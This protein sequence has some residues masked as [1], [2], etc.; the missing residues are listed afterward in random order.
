VVHVSVLGQEQ[1]RH[2][3][4]FQ[5]NGWTPVQSDEVPGVREVLIE[6]TT[7]LCVRSKTIHARA[8]KAQNDAALGPIRNRQE[9]LGEGVP[10]KG[11]DH[12]TARNY[13]KIGARSSALKCHEMTDGELQKTASRDY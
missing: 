13:N 9:L 10:V 3:A 5:A 1:R 7:Q 12:P 11:G 2:F 4:G 6:G 8:L